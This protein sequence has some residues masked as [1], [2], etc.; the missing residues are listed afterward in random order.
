MH[1]QADRERGRQ[2]DGWMDGWLMASRTR[3]SVSP[4]H[5]SSRARKQPSR[6]RLPAS[7]VGAHNCTFRLR[8]SVYRASVPREPAE[9]RPQGLTDRLAVGGP[10][11]RLQPLRP[12]LCSCYS[13]RHYSALA[14]STAHSVP[15]AVDALHSWSLSAAQRTGEQQCSGEATNGAFEEESRRPLRCSAGEWLMPRVPDEPS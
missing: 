9:R 14:L 4:H 2:A 8:C 1:P 10:P 11:L 5:R 6:Q 7:P 3:T 12:V 13:R 15:V